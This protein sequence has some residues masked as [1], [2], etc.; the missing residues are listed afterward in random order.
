M[1]PPGS[2][3]FDWYIAPSAFLSMLVASV[4]SCGKRLTPIEADAETSTPARSNGSWSA[5]W[6]RA[7]TDSAT[8][9]RDSVL[10]SEPIP[11][12]RSAS[13]RRNSS[14]PCRATM[15]VSRV[16]PRRRSASCCRELVAR[17]MSE[18]VV[19]ELEVVEI[20][21][22]H[23]DTEVVSA[24]ASDRGVEHL[25]EERPIGQAGEL[26]VIRQ[27]RHLLLGSLAVVMSKI[28]P[29]INQGSPFSSSIG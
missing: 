17:M 23:S 10:E 8:T 11:R 6:T 19:H 14:P 2:D 28:T 3:F 12:S 22:E 25:L 9:T 18:R 20:E 21:V 26:V 15:S 4:A 16:H 24:R 27:E 1:E 13:S 5:S 29:W 7:A